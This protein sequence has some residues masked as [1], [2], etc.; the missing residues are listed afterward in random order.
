MLSIKVVVTYFVTFAAKICSTPDTFL[1]SQN[2]SRS[3][4]HDRAA[5]RPSTTGAPPYIL[6]FE[7]R[8][9]SQFSIMYRAA[10]AR[11]SDSGT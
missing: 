2:L 11:D 5:L 6:T 1:Y 8:E 3:P 9:G 10:P 7:R 4:D